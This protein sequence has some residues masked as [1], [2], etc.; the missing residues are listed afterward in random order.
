MDKEILIQRIELLCA[1][2]K[3]KPTTAY[4]E[5]GV[6]KN[7]KS[8]LS[9]ANPSLAKITLLANYL[10]VS[11]EYL[12]GET[13]NRQK[14]TPTAEGDERKK[15]LIELFSLLDDAGQDALIAIAQQMKKQDK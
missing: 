11:R 9:V 12:L 8:N 10:N 6:G 3:I 7:F 13:E 14:E 4:I 5:S 1:E 15:E 2:R